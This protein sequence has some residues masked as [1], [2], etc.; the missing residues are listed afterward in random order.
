[1]SRRHRAAAAAIAV[2]LSAASG[3][4]VLAMFDGSAAGRS[5]GYYRRD[6][7]WMAVALCV[8]GGTGAAGLLGSSVR[9]WYASRA[10]GEA[11]DPVVVGVTGFSLVQLLVAIGLGAHSWVMATAPMIVVGRPPRGEG[12]RCRDPRRA[13]RRLIEEYGSAGVFARLA[14]E[15]AALGAPRELEARCIDAAREELRHAGM[16]V[17]LRGW[18]AVEMAP[19][20]PSRRT[21][22]R[23]R[24]V[25]E[26]VVDGW[27]NEGL[28]SLSARAEKAGATGS[29]RAL[30][31]VIAAE[32][33]H[34]ARLGRD[35][36]RWGLLARPA[37][38]RRSRTGERLLRSLAAGRTIA[39]HRA[40][41]PAG[42][43]TERG[44]GFDG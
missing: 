35:V 41:P 14:C 8:V 24:I 11:V 7:Y 19:W 27:I 32:E 37:P 38:G 42:P 23:A 5:L 1:M 6:T 12:P 40:H 25:Y 29:D 43:K 31:D 33:A 44:F 13:D 17:A 22:R 28:A 15:L 16:A 10:G 21:P 26:N 4:V 39:A 2:V 9:R 20:S 36:A 34:H 30:W 3:L 18:E